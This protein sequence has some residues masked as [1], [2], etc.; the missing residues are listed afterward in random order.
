MVE[1]HNNHCW[2]QDPPMDAKINAWNFEEKQVHIVS[3]SY[4]P[5]YDAV[6]IQHHFIAKNVG[7][8]ANH[9]KTLDKPKLGNI[10]QNKPSVLLKSVKIMKDKEKLKNCQRLGD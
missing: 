4:L 9:E 10:L 6:R 2:G 3:K 8:H 1:Y 5:W 7:P